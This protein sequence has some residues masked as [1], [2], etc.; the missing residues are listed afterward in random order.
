M[1]REET[2]ILSL[3]NERDAWVIYCSLHILNEGGLPA[4]ND[5]RVFAPQLWNITYPRGE[6]EEQV[7]AADGGDDVEV[8]KHNRKTKLWASAKSEID[9]AWREEFYGMGSFL[10]T[11]GLSTHGIIPRTCELE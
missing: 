3:E 1:A 11:D 7:V 4:S 2:N 6:G 10:N 9:V 5:M 8:E